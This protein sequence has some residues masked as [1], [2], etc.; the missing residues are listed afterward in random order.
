MG[1]DASKTSSI[2][3]AADAPIKEVPK[4]TSVATLSSTKAPDSDAEDLQGT[5]CSKSCEC[6]ASKP[7]A[8]LSFGMDTSATAPL[9]GNCDTLDNQSQSE[10]VWTIPGELPDGLDAFGRNSDAGGSS[11]TTRFFQDAAQSTP[12]HG[13]PS[14]KAAPPPSVPG[15]KK[16][17]SSLYAQVVID[18]PAGTSFGADA[19]KA[20]KLI[21]RCLEIRKKY[22][23]PAAG[24]RV[25]PR[26]TRYCDKVIAKIERTKALAIIDGECGL[27]R[28]EGGKRKILWDPY[29]VSP[30][31]E[32][33]TIEVSMERGVFQGRDPF[34]QLVG[35]D[36]GIQVDEFCGDYVEMLKAMRDRDCISFCEPRLNELELKFDLHLHRNATRE[37]QRQAEVSGRDWYQVRKVDTHIHHSACFTQ[38]Q[39]MQFIRKKIAEEMDTPVAEEGGKVMN[40][41]EVLTS[42]GV[43]DSDDVTADAV[44]C[45]ASIGNGGQH[46]TFGRFDRFNGK[47]NPF[48]NKLLREI[49]LKSDNFIQGRYLAELTKEVM[50]S[51]RSAKFVN[52]E[53]RISIYGKSLD[54]WAKLASW[55]R[56]YDIQCQ[57]VRWVIQVPRLY[58]LFRKIGAVNNFAEMLRNVFEPL[59]EA[60]ADPVK[61]E[62][63]FYMLQQVVGF[64]SVDDE[65]QGSH[66]TLKEYPHPEEW[67]SKTE[68]PPY[69][70]WMYYMYANIRSLN[71]LRRTR[72]LNTFQFRPHCGE[73]G[74]ASHLCSGFMLADSVCHGVQLKESPVLQYLFYLGQVGLAVSPLSNDILFVPLAESPFGTFF[75]RGLNVSL[76]TDDPLIIHMTEESLIEEYL[77]A[78]RTFRLSFCDLCEI[79]R[80]SVLQSG[81]EKIFKE[82]WIGRQ[83]TEANEEHEAKSNVPIIRL[84]FRQACHACEMEHVEAAAS[85]SPK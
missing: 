67:D 30:P 50:A 79:A 76:S 81:F 32:D 52:G 11:M 21:R 13:R 27:S 41:R 19:V 84:L 75:R 60:T 26:T 15:S 20:A 74:N 10:L 29:A 53:W 4:S 69:T 44:C 56:T 57:Q 38:R 37:A 33:V 61:H 78:A 48:G 3:A 77:V 51:Y 14:A 17:G 66:T 22:V 9:C 1:C 80:N 16:S 28:W 85:V 73:A 54:E 63:L 49:F 12:T 25:E 64:D 70:Y 55:F 43:F 82:W 36:A 40:L 39:L 8:K 7:R 72:G 35:D 31:P 24:E 58:K 62:D 71:S 65:S 47:Y 18:D 42:V 83:D 45:M 2:A 46:E 5:P 68:N 6:P 23:G 59:F 34:G